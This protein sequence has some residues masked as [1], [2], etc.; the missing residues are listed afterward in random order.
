MGHLYQND[1]QKQPELEQK[2]K[3][4]KSNGKAKNNQGNTKKT[5]RKQIRP[6]YELV[7]SRYRFINSV[8]FPLEKYSHRSQQN[9]TNSQAYATKHNKT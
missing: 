1:L 8:Q 6:T 5:Q 4:K 3:P 7:K 2:D 9:T